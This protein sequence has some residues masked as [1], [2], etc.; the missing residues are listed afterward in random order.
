MWREGERVVGALGVVRDTTEEKVLAEQLLQQEKLAAVGQLVSGV[1]HELNNPLAG[2]MAFSQLL[3]EADELPDDTR[4]ALQTIN[5][6]ARRAARIVTSLLTFAR[7]HQPERV[8]TDVNQV[9]RDTLELRRH[10]MRVHEIEIEVSLEELL[11]P[12]WADPFQLQQVVLNL[13]GNAEHALEDWSGARRVRVAT[14][15]A[16]DMLAISVSDSGPGIEKDRIARIFNPF[17]TTKAV[18]RGT[19]LGLSISDGIVREHGGRIRVESSPGRGATFIVELPL[20]MAPEGQQE[21]APIPE[22]Q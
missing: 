19:G 14:S 18:G 1:A 8:I 3:L 17:Y 2:V 7:Q 4:V 13:L 12:T 10:V 22:E 15:R 9:V 16:E 5:Q 11:P 6:E 20:V 21:P